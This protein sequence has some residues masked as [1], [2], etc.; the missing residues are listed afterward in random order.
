MYRLA[1]SELQEVQRQITDLLSKQL[2]APFTSPLSAPI[3]FVDKKTEEHSMVVV[4]RALMQP[5]M[6][7]PRLHSRLLLVITSLG[8]VNGRPAMPYMPVW[9]LAVLGLSNF[10]IKYMQGHANL[11]RPLTD[12][13]QTNVPF[14]WTDAWNGALR[15]LKHALTSAPVLALPDSSRPFELVCDISGFAIGAVLLQGDRP[16]AYYSR[17]MVAA[18]RNY[19]VT[20]QE[21]L[22]AVEALR[23]FQ[24]HLLSGQQFNM[25]IHKPN[26]FCTLKLLFSGVKHL[27]V[28][29]CSVPI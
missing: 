8:A 13:S 6:T 27:G 21:P 24:C 10:F 28:D 4:Y 18:E 1:P 25:V 22:A 26:M 15:H 11:T 23:V 29:I 12:L 19:V 2:I 17:K 14:V 20:E 9:N 7:T 3:L 16:V 5:L